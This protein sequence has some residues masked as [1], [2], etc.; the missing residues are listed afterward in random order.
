MGQPFKPIE[1]LGRKEIRK[2]LDWVYDRAIADGAA[3]PGRIANKARE[4]LRAVVSWVWE[5]DLID[6]LPRFP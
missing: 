5:H 4:H 6:S 3:N 1:R 2:I